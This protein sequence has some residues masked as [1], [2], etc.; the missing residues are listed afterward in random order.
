MP[1]LAAG[2]AERNLTS[3]ILDAS[4]ITNVD[5]AAVEDLG[6]FGDLRYERVWG[7]VHGVVAPTRT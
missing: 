1:T 5:V 3:P 4:G 6:G 2:G 7:S